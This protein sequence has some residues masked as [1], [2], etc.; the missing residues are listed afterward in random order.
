[1]RRC[2]VAVAL[3]VGATAAAGTPSRWEAIFS[4]DGAP[5]VHARVRYRDAG[6][7]EH[8]LELWRTARALRRDT[9]GALSV[10]VERRAGGDDQ[11]HV[12]Q[13]AGGRAYDVSRD[14]LYRMGTFPDWMQLATL[15]ARPRGDVRV[16]RLARDAEK[17]AAGSCRWYEAATATT[18]ERICWSTTLRLP[19]VVEREAGGAWSRVATVDSARPGPIA[20]ATFASDGRVTRVDI[21][22]DLD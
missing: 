16:T 3:L 20:A 7:A 12:V 8:S 2:A 17:T 10:V 6:G 21:D 1:M 18:H 19:L 22:R 13:R 11:Y 9:D 14:A 15:L 5:P 4:A